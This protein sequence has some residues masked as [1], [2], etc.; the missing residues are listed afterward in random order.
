MEFLL[1]L[2]SFEV[3]FPPVYASEKRKSG[4]KGENAVFM[5]ILSPQPVENSVDNVE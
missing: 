5:G 3:S 4:K 1:V 2:D